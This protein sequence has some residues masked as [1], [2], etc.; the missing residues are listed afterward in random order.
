MIMIVVR[1][2]WK[3]FGKNQVLRDLSLEVQTGETL[4]VLG[5]SGVGKSVLLKHIMGLTKPDEGTIEVNGTEITS[6]KENVLYSAVRNMGML[7]QGSALFDSMTIGENTAFYLDQ[8]GDPKTGLP[9]SKE[10]IE[11]RI[12]EALALVNLTNTE[13]L[14]PSDL[15]GGM[16]KRAA[17]A[18]L[19]VYRPAI[20]LY[21]EPTTGLDPITA[22]QINDLI[23]KTKKELK[24]TSIVVTHDIRS[25]LEVGDRLAFHHEGKIAHIAPRD[26]FFRS[27]NP[28]IK[29]FLH[30]AFPN[31]VAENNNN[32][33][34]G[35]L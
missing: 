17:L 1:N 34:A 3:S 26:D 6:L 28:L 22:M 18:R 15:S 23:N 16:R 33:W 21:D 30:K 35:G 7:F 31:H 10:E 5:R 29:D 13:H 27:N 11:S 25:A 24:A 20:L 4:V 32:V 19:I 2:L 14:M 12:A 8:H 9:L